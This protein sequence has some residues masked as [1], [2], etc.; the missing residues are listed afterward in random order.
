MPKLSFSEVLIL[1][2]AQL[3][4]VAPEQGDIPQCVRNTACVVMRAFC[5]YEKEVS[6]EHVSKEAV[7]I[8]RDLFSEA[9]SDFVD[10]VERTT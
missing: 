7:A 2:D 10:T 8:Y 5:R 6:A 9:L 1:L 4:Y 3:A